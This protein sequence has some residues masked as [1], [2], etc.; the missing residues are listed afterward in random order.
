MNPLTI[1]LQPCTAEPPLILLLGLN[2]T[3]WLDK[4][5]PYELGLNSI[6]S[7]SAFL[8]LQRDLEVASQPLP[9]FVKRSDDINQAVAEVL[10]LPYL[11]AL[12]RLD[13]VEVAERKG[14]WKEVAEWTVYVC[15]QRLVQR[16]YE[17]LLVEGKVWTLEEVR[18]RRD[19]MYADVVEAYRQRGPARDSGEE[20]GQ[21]VWKTEAEAEAKAKEEEEE[22]VRPVLPHFHPTATAPRRIPSRSTSPSPSAFTAVEGDA[23]LDFAFSLSVPHLS[24]RTRSRSPSSSSDDRNSC[25]PL[26]SLPALARSQR[27]SSPPSAASAS[28]SRMSTLARSPI[29]PGVRTIPH[30]ASKRRRRASMEVIDLT[31]SDD[32]EGAGC[33]MADL[34]LARVGGQVKCESFDE[35]RLQVDEGF[36]VLQKDVAKR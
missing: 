32:D 23:T 24:S 10:N 27:T 15:V 1:L 14:R 29:R 3:H 36:A 13:G 11:Q 8:L 20:G 26:A 18:R 22:D 34:P 25:A 33:T 9:F 30:P 19:A 31:Q 2:A 28:A 35:L 7:Y 21:G 12:W 16:A 4:L 17:A 6:L 5:A